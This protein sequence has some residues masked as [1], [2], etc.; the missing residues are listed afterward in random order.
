MLKHSDSKSKV[1]E[2]LFGKEMNQSFY[3]KEGLDYLA[4]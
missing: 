4:F 3:R 1:E 2:A